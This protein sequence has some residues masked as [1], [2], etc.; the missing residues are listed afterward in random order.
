MHISY[1]ALSL[2]DFESLFGYS[3]VFAKIITNVFAQLLM[4]QT[5]QHE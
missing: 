4:N 5:L 3:S 1:Q 2:S